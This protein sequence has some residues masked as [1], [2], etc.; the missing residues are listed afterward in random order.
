MSTKRSTRSA[1]FGNASLGHA[2]APA[3]VPRLLHHQ[4]LP[5]QGRALIAMEFLEVRPGALLLLL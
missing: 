4:L 1:R 2:C 5:E 3:A